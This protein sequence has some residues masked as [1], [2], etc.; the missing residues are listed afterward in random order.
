MLRKK[1]WKQRELAFLLMT[2]E[3][4]KGVECGAKTDRFRKKKKKKKRGWKCCKLQWE[5]GE[6]EEK[7]KENSKADSEGSLFAS[8]L[9]ASLHPGLQGSD[10]TFLF[11]HS[12]FLFRFSFILSLCINPSGGDKN[13]TAYL[14]VA[15]CLGSPLFL[16]L[17]QIKAWL[18]NRIRH[19][20]TQLWIIINMYAYTFKKA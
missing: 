5:E 16:S 19:N 4:V 13:R 8:H 17:P 18:R 15:V 1:I 2:E 11:F 20:Y 14:N 3:S 7:R 12:Q 9:L 6:E 10:V